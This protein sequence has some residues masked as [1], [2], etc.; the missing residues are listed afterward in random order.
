MDAQILFVF[1]VGHSVH[2][3]RNSTR[4]KTHHWRCTV[5][6]WSDQYPLSEFVNNVVF[7]LHETFKNPRQ[8]V[9]R[10]PFT[11]EED[12]FG[13]FRLF[14]RVSFLNV[15]TDLHYDITLFDN[16][17]LHAFRTVR[18]DPKNSEE[19]IRYSQ[20]GGIPIPRSAS[21]LEIQQ[22][23]VEPIQMSGSKCNY[24]VSSFYPEIAMAVLNPAIR[25]SGLKYASPSSLRS[26]PNR[27][28]R[29]QAL[30]NLGLPVAIASPATSNPASLPSMG[31]LGP[32]PPGHL[33]SSF[34]HKKK[35]Q[36]K[37]EAQLR[38]E[39]Q[40][41]RDPDSPPPTPASSSLHPS[42]APPPS[43]LSINSSSL[44]FTSHPV[45]KERIVLRLYRSDLQGSAEK[46]KRKKIGG[47]HKHRHRHHHQ[48]ELG[49]QQQS[50]PEVWSSTSSAISRTTPHLQHASLAP[51]EVMGEK[52]RLHQSPSFNADMEGDSCSLFPPGEVLVS[53]AS[54]NIELQAKSTDLSESSNTVN[55][56]QLDT[57]HATM[58]PPLPPHSNPRLSQPSPPPQPLS[59]EQQQLQKFFVERVEK[60]SKA[61]RNKESKHH[62]RNQEQKTSKHDS[63]PSPTPSTST[64]QGA[65]D[66]IPLKDLKRRSD[67]TDVDS[68]SSRK[69]PREKKHECRESVKSYRPQA[70]D[71]SSFVRSTVSSDSTPP[72]SGEAPVPDHLT[73]TVPVSAGTTTGIGDE[74]YLDNEELERLYDRVLCLENECMALQMAKVL[75][76][77]FR[78]GEDC[79]VDILAPSDELPDYP[80][81]I[82]FDMRKM[83]LACVLEM[84]AVISADERMSAQR[85]TGAVTRGS[86]VEGGDDA[87]NGM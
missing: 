11:I 51:L 45:Q 65:S 81:I 41:H 58:S 13:S 18:L 77:Y 80:Q 24:T 48:I 62:H 17:E 83:P 59:S 9:H 31:V 50:R 5:E 63:S 47:K 23:V 66:H 57:Q 69:I 28:S 39:N 74:V 34:K 86:S 68:S 15:F 20:Y 71:L 3:R 12:G 36:L 61:E 29:T 44:S 75:R 35:L 87:S 85:R 30:A 32:H 76:S 56:P 54:S 67:C 38:L 42:A 60:A 16:R 37:H 4:E 84:T 26:R 78:P 52:N 27:E 8:V 49:Q 64:R 10:E 22:R 21:S 25:T 46:E 1:K 70:P 82:A 40:H 14:A 55:F 43:A 53:K 2:R 79:G 33:P 7:Q 72:M 6:S 73:T 19:W